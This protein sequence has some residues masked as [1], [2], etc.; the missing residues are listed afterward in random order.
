MTGPSFADSSAAGLLGPYV[1]AVDV[2]EL[3]VLRLGDDRQVPRSGLPL[4]HRDEGSCTRRPGVF[5]SAIGVV[6]S[7]TRGSLCRPVTSPL[8]LRRKGAANSGAPRGRRRDT[9]A[10]VVAPDER[11]VADTHA[12]DVGDRVQRAPAS[13]SRSRCQGLVLSRWSYAKARSIDSGMKVGVMLAGGRHG[14]CRRARRR[15]GRMCGPWR[16]RQKGAASTPSGSGEHRLARMPTAR[17]TA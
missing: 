5:V 8:P 11:R 6:R 9:R 7:P 13:S 1:E 17:C 12:G 10:H 2:V 15:D 16:R 3:A 4:P 14:R